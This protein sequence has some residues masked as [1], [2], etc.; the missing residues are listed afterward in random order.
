MSTPST[1]I[2]HL[3]NFGRKLSESVIKSIEELV[4]A[5]VVEELVNVN[6]DLSK[7]LFIQVVSIVDKIPRE[8]L[9][10]DENHRVVINL[11]GLPVAAVYIIT[12]LH[13]RLGVF[14]PVLEMTKDVN[15]DGLFASFKLKKVVDLERERISS[16]SRMFT[17]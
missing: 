11:C 15:G 5:T 17:A 6:L 7:N 2:I 13:A 3:L 9:R 14:P 10:I 8:S 4:K 12:E 1:R 16:R